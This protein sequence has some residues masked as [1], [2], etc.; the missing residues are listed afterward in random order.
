M[1]QT[2]LF[3]ARRVAVE[4]DRTA[5]C[6]R[7]GSQASALFIIEAFA[8]GVK[9]VDDS[10]MAVHR[11]PLTHRIRACAPLQSVSDI[12]SLAPVRRRRAEAIGRRPMIILP[13]PSQ[14]A[15]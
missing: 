2:S 4:N 13:G 7:A 11:A 12:H 14:E 15:T 3:G 10:L 6:H 1:A 9:L 8:R 5:W